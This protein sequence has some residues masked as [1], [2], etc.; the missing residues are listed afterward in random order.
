MPRLKSFASAQGHRPFNWNRFI[1][2]R[3]Y[4]EQ[5]L[6]DA[7]KLSGSF[8]TCACGNQCVEIPR[9]DDYTFF[10]LRGEPKDKILSRYGFEFHEHIRHMYSAYLDGRIVGLR[11]DQDRA[12][13]ILAKIEKRSAWILA[14]LAKKGAREK[15][16]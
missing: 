6:S 13:E 15:A 1:N 8:V 9:H 3:T 10:N 4:T 11:E 12:Q 7:V 16:A 14:K 5:E 2:K